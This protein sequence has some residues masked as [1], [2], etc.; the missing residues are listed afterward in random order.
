MINNAEPV[1]IPGRTGVTLDF[2]ISNPNA[3][4]LMAH[5]LTLYVAS[6]D[7]G[8]LL[9]KVEN[10]GAFSAIYPTRNRVVVRL[11]P[12]QVAMMTEGMTYS[13]ELYVHESGELRTAALA[14][15]SLAPSSRLAP[16]AELGFNS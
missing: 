10:D 1:N 15:L 12:E 6:D 5:R 16:D 4:D 14:G 3:V 11:A 13:A 7:Q 2:Q 9:F 8:T